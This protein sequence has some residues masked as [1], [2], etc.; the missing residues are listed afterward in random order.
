MALGPEHRPEPGHRRHVPDRAFVA[1]EQIDGDHRQQHV[2]RAQERDRAAEDGHHREEPPV[3]DDRSQP[4]AEL[5]Q[6]PRCAGSPSPRPAAGPRGPSG[7]TTSVEPRVRTAI[8]AY[9]AAGPARP[10]SSP[11]RSGPISAPRPSDRP[12]G[13]VRDRQLIGRLDD[14]GE[15]RGVR[16]PD[17]RDARR[18]QRRHE[19]GDDRRGDRERD[20]GRTHRQ[21]Q[22]RVGPGQHP[23][24]GPR[25]P[26]IDAAGATMIDGRKTTPATTPAS[27]G[28]PRE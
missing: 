16:R 12:G 11:A 24:A 5:P 13:G 19:V 28:P 2:E 15:E 9:T 6:Q 25:S 27:A 7:R 23:G 14:L 21:R 10:I 18:R 8:A 26:N 17:Q 22:D 20:R 1:A 3:A 4:G